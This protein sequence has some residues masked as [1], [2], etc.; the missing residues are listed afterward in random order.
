MASG[1]CR[2]DYHSRQA[3]ESSEEAPCGEGLQA[4]ACLQ[5][6]HSAPAPVPKQLPDRLA[7]QTVQQCKAPGGLCLKGSCLLQHA[8][9]AFTVLQ[10]FSKVLLAE[11]GGHMQTRQGSDHHAAALS[12]MQ[13][14][15]HGC[16]HRV[17]APGAQSQS[18]QIGAHLQPST[19]R[20]TV[21]HTVTVHPVTRQCNL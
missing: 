6:A 7:E 19:C 15:P 18:Q 8:L 9:R 4:A 1:C 21:P 16:K 10:S 17:H 20:P 5:A 13:A 14:W 11:P 3:C 2:A 12:C